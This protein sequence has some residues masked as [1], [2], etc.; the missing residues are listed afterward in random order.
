MKLLAT[1]IVANS[2]LGRSKSCDKISIRFDFCSKP[3]S[4][5]PRFKENSAT[6]EP[7]I[8]AEQ[9]NSKNNKTK[10]KTTETSIAINKSIKLAGSG[11]NYNWFS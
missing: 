4:T 6:S 2:F 7:E 5:S 3:D 9:T 10:L 8:S 11:S 1:N